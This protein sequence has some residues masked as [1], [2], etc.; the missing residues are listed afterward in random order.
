MNV[1]TSDLIITSVETITAFD[2]ETGDFRF[3]LDELQSV[4]ISQSQDSTDI[5]GKQG[6]R[7]NTL[8]R[9]K[10]VTI[11]G[12][13]GLISAGLLEL[14][15]GVKFEDRDAT[16]V[17]WTDYITTTVADQAVLTYKAVGTTGAEIIDLYIK[18]PNGTLGKRFEQA[19]AAETG[20]FSY[21]ADS[22]TITF[23]TDEVPVGTE[24]AVFYER[25]IKGTVLEN[26]SDTYSEKCQLYVDAICEDTCGAQYRMQIYI[27]KADFDGN[28]EMNMGDDQTVHSFEAS[29]LAGACGSGGSYFTWTIFGAN[30]GDVE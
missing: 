16:N 29:S 6:R 21:D 2:I 25:Q 10:A 24:L 17:M 22:K 11:S 26:P 19:S 20:K 12:D 28:W 18:N 27:P 13:N 3:S 4:T 7:L 9:N 1:N 15:T 23:F 8:K 14:Q 5:T 30:E